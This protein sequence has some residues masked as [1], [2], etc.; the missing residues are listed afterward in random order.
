[1]NRSNDPFEIEADAKNKIIETKKLDLILSHDNE[2]VVFSVRQIANKAGFSLIDEVLIA[3]AASEL[4]TNILRYAGKGSIKINIIC[5]VVSGITGIELLANDA[6]PGIKDIELALQENYST[7]VNSLGQGLPSVIKIMDEFH[8]KSESGK[9]TR[10]L[11]R[12]W[13][14]NE[15]N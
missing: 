14:K 15:E 12:K 1:M 4:A 10:I 9:G 13:L 8:I 3:V 7:Q 2:N 6:G 5:D 11:T